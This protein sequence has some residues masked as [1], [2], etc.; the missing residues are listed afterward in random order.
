MKQF[1]ILLLLL[2]TVITPT[3]GQSDLAVVLQTN[4]AP[5]QIG[6]DATLA[7]TTLTV[8]DAAGQPVP[9]AYLKLHLDAPPGNS[10]ISTDFPIVEGTPLINYAGTLPNGTLQF[11]YIYPIRGVYNFKVEAG[12]EASALTFSDTLTLSL[13]ENNREIF[14][15][16]LFFLALLGLGI[17]AGFIIGRGARG[18]QMAAAGITLLFTAGLLAGSVLPARAH[19]GGNVSSAEPFTQSATNG[20]VTLTYA[21]NP[22]AGRV[23]TLNQLNFSA[24]DDSGNP[25]PNTTFEVALWHIEDDKPVFATTLF[26]PTGKAHLEFQFFD[27]AEHDVRVLASNSLGNAQLARVIEVEGIS[28]PLPVKI[29]TTL[30][31]VLVVF[32]GILIGLRWQVAQGQKQTL[33]PARA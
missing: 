20:N 3:Y 30:Y 19:G 26:A 6:P 31:L 14:N 10:I 24:A 2:A 29:K 18:G 1:L 4:P 32:A 7:S 16:A 28:P 27:G 17:A 23:G 25:I 5:G 22:G 11:E 9:N 33:A 15:F 21:M 12:R 13:N 8:V